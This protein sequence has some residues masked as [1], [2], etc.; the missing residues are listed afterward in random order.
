ML[1][2]LVVIRQITS[3][4]SGL[5]IIPA[6]NNSPAKEFVKALTGGKIL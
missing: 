1:D 2:K 4:L 3:L 5:D 6:F